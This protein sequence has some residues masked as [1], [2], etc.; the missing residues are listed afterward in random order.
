VLASACVGGRIESVFPNTGCDAVT[1][2]LIVPGVLLVVALATYVHAP[3]AA[4]IDP[5]AALRQD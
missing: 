3:R 5:L 1:F 4:L 2:L